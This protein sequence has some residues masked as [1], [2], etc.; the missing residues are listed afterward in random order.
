MHTN[1]SP[2][3]AMHDAIAALKTRGFPY[4]QPSPY[5]LKYEDLNFWP[6]KGTIGR[7]GSSERL[8]ERGIEAFIALIEQ[9]ERVKEE[10]RRHVLDQAN[11]RIN[12][13]GRGT[14]TT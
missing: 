13:G 3:E 9:R 11:Q 14:S 10:R 4:K 6:T 8:P 2:H 12:I 7:D 5:H 1:K